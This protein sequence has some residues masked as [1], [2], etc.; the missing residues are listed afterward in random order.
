MDNN[1]PAPLQVVAFLGSAM[2]AGVLVLAT[3][4]GFL[5][6]KAWAKKTLLVL[7]GGAVIY[8]GFLSWFS[9]VSRDVTLARGSE[10]YFC[11]I[12]CHLAYSIVEVKPVADGPSQELAVTVRTR[13]DENTISPRRSKEAPLTPN[14]R[15]VVL[16]DTAGRRY[17][18]IATVGTPLE[19][20]LVPGKAYVTTLVFGV[21]DVSPGTRLLITSP[22]GPV[23]LLIGNEMSLGHKKTYLAL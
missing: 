17:L 3:I 23:A 14:A 16:V 5:R 18:P 1:F 13:F 2:L 8:F 20:E 21:T 9:A 7:A 10:K 11:E 4:Y 15:E 6:Q 19:N 22:S 12:D